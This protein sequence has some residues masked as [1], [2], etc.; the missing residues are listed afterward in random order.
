M[1]LSVPM[2]VEEVAGDRARCSAMGEERWV[3]LR[4]MAGAPPRE[5]DYVRINRGF[6]QDVVPEAEALEAY[7]LFADILA[8]LDGG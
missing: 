8:T 4:L 5:G 2:K 6:A 3:D 7:A 1:C